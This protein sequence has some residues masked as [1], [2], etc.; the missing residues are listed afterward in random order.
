MAI[1]KVKIS[2]SEGSFGSSL[3]TEDGVA[4]LVCYHSGNKTDDAGNTIFGDGVV[5]KVQRPEDLAKYDVTSSS[6]TSYVYD[7]VKN[8]YSFKGNKGKVLYV[9][10]S[11]Q[12]ID[13][14]VKADAKIFKSINDNENLLASSNNTIN[15]IGFALKVGLVADAGKVGA[16]NG[17]GFSKLLKAQLEVAQK[18]ADA[19]AD[20]GNE[21]SFVFTCPT[22]TDKTK[23][24]LSTGDVADLPDWRKTSA[25]YTGGLTA[26]NRC[27]VLMTTFDTQL[28]SVGLVIG[29]LSSLSVEGNIGRVSD[30]ALPIDSSKVAN[31]VDG[32]S[33]TGRQKDWDTID[34]K[35]YIFFIKRRGKNGYFFNDDPTLTLA[36][37][38]RKNITANRIV[39]KATR[40]AFSLYQE[41]L[42]DKIA[43]NVKT[44]KLAKSSIAELQV[45]VEEELKDKM[46]AK[47]EIQAVA[48]FVDPDQDVSKGDIKVNLSIVPFGYARTINVVLGLVQK[49]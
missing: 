41:K 24:T 16:T 31:F 18:T 5:V 21:M 7:E 44:G 30:G 35:G 9:V 20:E 43:T 27:S 1:P 17:P 40:L 14:H 38:D 2:Y 3:I 19:L 12:T 26:Y 10:A 28:T 22:W 45:S 23:T 42:L 13:A 46:Q 25:E 8:Y 29:K 47:G 33:V 36:D 39:D 15:M 6:S 49:V 32:T 11:D 48:A 4:A 37:N 34:N